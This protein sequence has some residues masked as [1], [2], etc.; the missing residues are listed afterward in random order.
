M[1]ISRRKN[2]PTFLGKWESRKVTFER[3]V[4]KLV[5]EK[6][7]PLLGKKSTKKG[8]N[9]KNQLKKERGKMGKLALEENFP[10]SGKV[11]N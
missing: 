6:N 5:S 8:K 2:F 1:T 3:K 7:F 11:E 9:G 10:F 4:G